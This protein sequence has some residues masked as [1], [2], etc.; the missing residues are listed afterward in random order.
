MKTKSVLIMTAISLLCGCGTSST[1]ETE[2][3]VDHESLLQT[4]NQSAIPVG[5]SQAISAGDGDAVFRPSD[6]VVYYGDLSVDDAF[7]VYCSKTGCT[8][9]TE[10]CGAYIGN[11]SEFIA[12]KGLWYYIRTMEDKSMVL[13]EHDPETN[14]RT[15]LKTVTSGFEG[16]TQYINTMQN[17]MVSYDCLYV[18]VLEKKTEN[19]GADSEDMMEFVEINLK[20][21]EERTIL[22]YEPAKEGWYIE[23]GNGKYLLIGQYLP[24]SEDD[25]LSYEMLYAYDL[26]TLTREV[27]IDEAAG[28]LMYADPYGNINSDDLLIYCTEHEVHLYDTNTNED[29][30]LYTTDERIIHANIYGNDVYY[31]YF[32]D[33]STLHFMHG[34]TSGDTPVEINNG[35]ENNQTSF[36]IYRTTENGYLGMTDD[37]KSGWIYREDFIQEN[38]DAIVILS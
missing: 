23:A 34:N 35:G 10:D 30:Q 7:T 33:N 18:Q 9:D 31:T 12:Y 29:K 22:S 20:T 4:E 3:T 6:S 11:A 5:A 14:E 36:S 15:A 26:S 1:K 16:N 25:P 19:P 13:F 8:H 24:N 21:K 38:Y 27:I 17:M 2:T 37:G 28:M 32:E